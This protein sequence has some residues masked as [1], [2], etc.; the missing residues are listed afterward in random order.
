MPRAAALLT[1][2][3]G[4]RRLHSAARRVA[5]KYSLAF[6]SRPPTKN[7]PTR[8]RLLQAAARVFARDGLTGAT[9]RAI[10]RE[11]QVNEVT[12]FRH[13][14]TKQRLLAAVVQENFGGDRTAPPAVV[15]HSTSLRADL[16]EHARRYE[17]LLEDNL[18]LIRTMVGEIHHH[19]VHE[20]QVFKSIFRPLRQALIA[21]LE[22][23]RGEH[24]IRRGVDPV[25]LSDLF[26][27]MIFT[28]V[29]RRASADV[30]K[31][32]GAGDYLASAVELVVRGAAP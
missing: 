6:M 15:P 1:D 4:S 16:L 22:A 14:Q 26:G 2:A 19:G 7:S 18:P 28:G 13:F 10:A 29:L 25:I 31:E 24:A 17:R 9:T 11:A 3:I 8:D 23:A 5:C 32:Y 30:E 12:L 21:R 20:R 27:G